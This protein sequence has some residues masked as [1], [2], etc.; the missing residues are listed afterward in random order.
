MERIVVVD[1]E[2]RL[3][4]EGGHLLS[5]DEAAKLFRRALVIREK[6][7]GPDHPDTA[8]SLANV[9]SEESKLGNNAEVMCDEQHRH[10]VFAL[11]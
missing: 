8:V 7:L 5:T 4:A 2:D 6:S 10:S 3:V 9:A 1:E 11:Q